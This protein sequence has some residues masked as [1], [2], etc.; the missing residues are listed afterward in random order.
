MFKEEFDRIQNAPDLPW[1]PHFDPIAYEEEHRPL[2]VEQNRLTNA[3]LSDWAGVATKIR[4]TTMLSAM[5]QAQDQK[6]PKGAKKS[7]LEKLQQKI[8][9]Q[10]NFGTKRILD[11]E[12][13]AKTT[14]EPRGGRFKKRRRH[15]LAVAE[16][17]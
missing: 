13:A 10:T 1:A 3:Q 17:V 16:C 2:Q 14:S 5:D 7:H 6:E 9:T 4:N 8:L 12:A 11:E 15:E